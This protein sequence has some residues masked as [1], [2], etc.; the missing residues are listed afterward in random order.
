M[1]GSNRYY[2]WKR[3]QPD[4]RDLR[5]VPAP[6]IMAALPPAA[7]LT[8]GMG[9]VLDQGQLGS[10]GPNSIDSLVMFDQHKQG[11]RVES[12]SRL[13]TYYTTR[14]LMGTTSYDSGVDNRTMLKALHQY[15]FCAET[16]WPYDPVY[17]EG[18]H[19]QTFATVPPQSAYAA[20]QPN[21]I[22]NY[23]AVAQD[24]DSIRGCIASGFP[25]LFGFTVY[26]SFESP[27]VTHTGMVPMPGGQERVLGGHDVCIVGY[28][29]ATQRLKFKNS[30]NGWGEN[31]SGYG[32]FPYAY[33]LDSHLSS[34]FWVIN[35]I[36]GGVPTP[37]PSGKLFS[38]TFN[39]AVPKNGSVS[40]RT[41][42]DIPVGKYDVVPQQMA[43]DRTYSAEAEE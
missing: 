1:S 9:T 6:Q 4:R 33:A 7:D 5:F 3:Q 18:D 35:A 23:S 19:Q 43:Q 31:N 12:I 36:P 11:I 29:D 26:E 14:Q 34:D 17:A 38:L 13:F 39:R 32:Y 25:F 24:L 16:L 41:P 37:P 22:S 30:W 28:N 8:T 42:V 21:A 27:Q 40:F 20:A 15:G 10:C 2:G